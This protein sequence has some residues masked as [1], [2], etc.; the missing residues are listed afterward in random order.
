MKIPT[1]PPPVPPRSPPSNRMSAKP[2]SRITVK[3]RQKPNLSYI[4]PTIPTNVSQSPEDNPN[5]PR[6]PSI[7]NPASQSFEATQT[8]ASTSQSVSQSPI[9]TPPKNISQDRDPTSTPP[10]Q[11]A[12]SSRS[13]S[14]C[15]LPRASSHSS[16]IVKTVSQSPAPPP[17]RDST[18]PPAKQ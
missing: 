12:S 15:Q 13:H 2:S 3:V 5:F 14:V 6:K 4:S 17:R 7:T 16:S 1:Q 18:M 11:P 10:S 8:A 9:V